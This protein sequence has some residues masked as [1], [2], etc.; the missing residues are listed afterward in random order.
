VT[1]LPEALGR[2]PG[3]DMHPGAAEQADAATALEGSPRRPLRTRRAKL[4]P[5]VEQL[6]FPLSIYVATRLLYVVIALADTL[7]HG[8]SF[9]RELQ[10]WDGVWYLSLV[11]HGYPKTASTLQ[12][13]LGFLPLYPLLV[14]GTSH[15]FFT[16]WLAAG[17]IVSTVGGFIATVLV[18]R[19]A[20][21]WWG[22]DAA[23]RVVIFFCLFPGSIVFSM[24]YSEGVLI[25][26]IAGCFI[27]LERRR[28]VLAGLLAGASTAVA[29]IALAIVPAC[30]VAAFLEIRRRG[31]QDREARRALWAPLLSP[32]GIALFAIFMWFWTGSPIASYT[33]Q[34]HGWSERTT[35]FSL[36]HVAQHLVD[37]IADAPSHLSHPGINLNYIS[38]LLGAAFLAWA[39]VLL[40]RTRPRIPAAPIVY[41]LGIAAFTFTSSM[42]QP[43]PRMLICAFPA[44]AVVAYRL[45]GKAYTRLLVI[46]TVLAVA[47]SLVTYVGVGLRP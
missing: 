15:L 24:V 28:W 38:G 22:E 4:A 40:F 7:I 10:N 34:H 20:T 31:W 1:T 14:Y 18:Q 43:N 42:T 23:R 9:G 6:R 39:I 27:A 37:Q 46:T 30:A 26:L 21:G 25:P 12:T 8:T 2:R 36:V 44:L 35:L 47:M 19:L 3:V 13:T 29:P 32:L 45:T 17:M 11:G 33:A 5:W 41:V 16:S